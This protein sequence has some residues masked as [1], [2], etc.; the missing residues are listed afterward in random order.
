MRLL[1]TDTLSFIADN[2][3]EEHSSGSGSIIFYMTAFDTKVYLTLSGVNN[4]IKIDYF[5]ALELGFDIESHELEEELLRAY[6]EAFLD[7]PSGGGIIEDE[8]NY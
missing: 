1:N 4:K 3:E 5:T 6:I 8:S 2:I 7:G